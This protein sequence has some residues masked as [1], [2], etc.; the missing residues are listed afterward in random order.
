MTTRIG[1]RVAGAIIL[2]ISVWYWIEAGNYTVAYGDPAG[3]GLV[4][5][6]IAV[7][8]GLFAAYLIIRP[9]PDPVWFRWPQVLGQAASLVILFVY[10]LLIEPLGFPLATILGSALLA[11]ILG[12]TWLKSVISGLVVG[13]GLFILFDF[14]FNLPLP[15]GPIFG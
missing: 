10:P 12:A 6:A 9:D 1:D 5:H 3:P 8:M 13:V 11:R 15:L 7:P 4:P 2:A 14:G